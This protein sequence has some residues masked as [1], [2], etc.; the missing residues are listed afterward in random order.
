[1]I[2]QTWR[3]M[4]WKPGELDSI[5]VLTL[6]AEPG[7]MRV[8]LTHVGVPDDDA[9]NVANGWENSYFKPWREARAAA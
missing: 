4:G 6:T 1:M 3:S 2:V 9:E 5:L 7:G 8:D